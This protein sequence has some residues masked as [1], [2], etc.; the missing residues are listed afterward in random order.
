MNHKILNIDTPPPPPTPHCRARVTRHSFWSL[1][2]PLLFALCGQVQA[3]TNSPATGMPAVAYASGIMVPTEDSA[4]T[5]NGGNGSTAI[6]DTDGLGTFSWQWS[7]ADT[8]GGAYAAIA[9]ATNAAFTP[10]DDEVGKFLQVCASFTDTA[11][12][13]EQRCLQ[14]ATAVA[15]VNDKPVSQNATVTVNANADADNPHPL[16]A[17]DFPFTDAD[18]D[19]LAGV[20][21]HSQPSS[22]IMTL[23]DTDLTQSNTP[24]RTITVVQLAAGALTYYPPPPAQR[25]SP[26]TASF[27]ARVVDDG[28]DGTDNKTSVGA[29]L[30]ITLTSPDQTAAT[31]RPSIIPATTADNPTYAEDA[32]LTASTDGITE[33]NGIDNSTLRWQW[34]SS[35]A[36]DGAFA[37]INGATGVLFTPLQAHV[38][39]YIRVCISFK[40]LHETPETVE[41]LCSAAARVRNVNDAP[42]AQN[43]AIN[44]SADATMSEPY[45]FTAADFPFADEDDDNLVSVEIASLPGAGTLQVDGADATVGRIVTAANIGA[46]AYWPA[47]EQSAQPGYAAFAFKVTDDGSD[48]SGNKTSATAATI[49]INLAEHLLLRLRIFLEGPLR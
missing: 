10:G 30:R 49:T 6:A 33:P 24:T 34:Q 26:F 18:G 21:I 27:Q 36:S 9:M 11:S 46:I 38:G 16:R 1:I 43:R 31:G 15:N 23:D 48:G 45:R 5:A 3:Q 20:I 22:G 14:I 37:D 28:D 8:N 41:D 2:L 35:P 29:D 25:R 32:E 13:A 19:M 4:I 44:V 39:L 42:R 40:D 17:S 12:N 7:A 47:A